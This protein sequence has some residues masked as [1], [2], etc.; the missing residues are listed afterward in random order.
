MWNTF[1]KQKQLRHSLR[2]VVVGAPFL[3]CVG[4]VLGADWPHWRGPNRND[5]TPESSGWQPGK[6]WVGAPA[7][8]RSVGIGSTSPILADNRVYVL[9]WS[10]GKDHVVCLDAA[11]G[12]TVWETTYPCPKYG[13]Y[14]IGDKGYY[15]GP[16]ATP[17]FDAATGLLYT[18]STDGDLAAWDTRKQGR[19]AWGLNLY[20]RYHVGRRPKMHRGLRDYG[21]TASP[22]LWRDWLLVEVGAP[23]GSLVAFN[24][25]TGQQVWAARDRDAAGHTGG[26]APMMVQGIP[27]AALLTLRNLLI[28]RLDDRHAG[29]TLA[30]YPWVTDFGCN[31][32]TPTVAG[33]CV[34]LTSGY[35]HKSLCKVRIAPGSAK[36]VSVGCP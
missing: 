1:R 19:R 2:R 7:W 15:G 13:R 8:R 29:E 33:D 27:C 5:V 24:K 12:R 21:R 26:P 4:T 32:P 9:G 23:A 25:R 18:L 16:S 34:Y 28:I 30:R 14:S 31:I 36:K 11:T 35:N 22:L 10:H 6:V 3:A 17:E 20:Q